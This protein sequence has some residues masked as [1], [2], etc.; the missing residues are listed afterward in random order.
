MRGMELAIRTVARARE[1]VFPRR[2]PAQASSFVGTRPFR[3][4]RPWHMAWLQGNPDGGPPAP[5]APA[6]SVASAFDAPASSKVLVV[7]DEPDVLQT[8]AEL[9][10][11]LGFE[12]IC[13]GSGPEAL[14]LLR[15]TT[16]IGM[17]VSDVRMPGMSGVALAHEAQQLSPELKIVLVSG[18]ATAE[19]WTRDA[20]G[21]P[22]LAKPFRTEDLERLLRGA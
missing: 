3:T 6:S 8:T 2:Y 14:E 10:R 15:T 1:E 4:I 5:Q 21:F 19:L 18:Y 22:L 9:L 20:P 7:D 11:I 12:V 16:G 13:A 17:L